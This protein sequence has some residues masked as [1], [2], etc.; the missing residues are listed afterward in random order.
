MHIALISP[1]HLDVPGGNVTAIQRLASELRRL[2]HE[3]DVYVPDQNIPA[4]KRFDVVHGLHALRGGDR[5]LLV[6][7]KLGI[8]VVIT[9]TGTD[10]DQGLSDPEERAH[11][12]RNLSLVDGVV[13]LHASQLA[14]ARERSGLAL[15]A[16]EVIEQGISVGHQPYRFRT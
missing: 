9:L 14:L 4:G 1:Y 3:V 15:A 8:P 10:V 2:D 11:V 16:S 7:E 12:L 5:A 6:G 13:A